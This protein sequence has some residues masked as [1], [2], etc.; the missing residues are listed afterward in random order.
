VKRVLVLRRIW[1]YFENN[2]HFFCIFD[3]YFE[4]LLV[5]RNKIEFF[6]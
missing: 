1:L 6:L 5:G 2:L 3:F 4:F